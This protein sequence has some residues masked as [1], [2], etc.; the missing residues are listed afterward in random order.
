MSTVATWDKPETN[1]QIVSWAV[2]SHAAPIDEDEP[3]RSNRHHYAAKWILA[4][5]ASTTPVNFYDPAREFHRS[6]TSS[7]VST[8]RRRRGASITIAQARQIALQVLTRANE[9]L[10]RERAEEA[11]FLEVSWND[12]DFA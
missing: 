6:H 8:I 9:C 3:V 10:A 11:R 5:L 12:E 1:Q 7:I 4:V 2:S